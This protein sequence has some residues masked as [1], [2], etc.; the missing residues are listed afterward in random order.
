MALKGVLARAE[1]AGAL[2]NDDA[3]M[4]FKVISRTAIPLLKIYAAHPQGEDLYRRSM[5]GLLA[6][7]P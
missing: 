6:K 3:M 4:S 7:A 2:L 1:E 5:L